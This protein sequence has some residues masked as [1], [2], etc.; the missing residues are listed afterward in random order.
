M[1]LVQLRIIAKDTRR[2]DQMTENQE[3]KNRR[4]AYSK[5]IQILELPDMVFKSERPWL[6]IFIKIRF[7]WIL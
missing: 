7:G 5:H 1:W 4:K 3:E 6:P 2:Q